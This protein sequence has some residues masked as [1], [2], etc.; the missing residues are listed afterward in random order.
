MPTSSAVSTE[1]VGAPLAGT[2]ASSVT[3][4][5]SDYDEGVYYPAEDGQPMANSDL[6]AVYIV[7]TRANLEALL[8]NDFVGSDI[9][10]YPV[11]GRPEICHAPDVLVALG[12]P[13]VVGGHRRRSYMQWKEDGVAPQVVFE[14]WS[15]GNRSDEEERKLR[16]YER[17]GVEEYYAYDVQTG[18]LEGWRRDGERL[19]AIERMEGWR[20]PRLG[21]VFTLEEGALRLLYPDGTPF[22]TLGEVRA[23]LERERA[24]KEAAL[25]AKERER[26]AKERERAA[27]EAALAEV[28]RL[29]EK[30]R[31][32]GVTPE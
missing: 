30:L 25:A 5:F 29:K 16:F 18:R 12:R 19:V 27:K 6:H 2:E 4:P 14:F 7:Q 26:A 23:A 1:F 31:A 15:E 22:Q 13:P 20:S 11:K 24:A 17:Y 10:W 32:L 28:E 21:I 8:P 9:F 3:N